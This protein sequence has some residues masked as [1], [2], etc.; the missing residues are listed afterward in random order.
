MSSPS[1][2]PWAIIFS[3]S[4]IFLLR[5][6][7]RYSPLSPER[8]QPFSLYQL[9]NSDYL[10]RSYCNSYPA[11]LVTPVPLALFLKRAKA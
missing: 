10:S 1:T 9:I 3:I 6:Y 2:V 7:N 11:K 5:S 8:L 4:W